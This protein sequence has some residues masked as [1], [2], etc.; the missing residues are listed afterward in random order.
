MCRK[1]GSLRFIQVT[2]FCFFNRSFFLQCMHSNAIVYKST[3]SDISSLFLSLIECVRTTKSYAA[4]RTRGNRKLLILSFQ[5]RDF[6]LEISF[7]ISRW[8]RSGKIK[9]DW[10]TKY[11]IA[12]RK[13]TAFSNMIVNNFK[14]HYH[15]YM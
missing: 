4:S 7:P 2:L 13:L 3:G 11:K 6:L 15:V 9:S 1:S 10:F 14:C 12:Q 8:C 5:S